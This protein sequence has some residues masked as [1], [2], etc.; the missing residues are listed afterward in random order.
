MN[1]QC[2]RRISVITPSY[3]QGQFLAE[4]IESVIGQEGDF[5]LDYIVV[6]G[7][8]T[9][10]SVEIIKHYENL[11]QNQ[12]WKVKCR[13]IRYRWISEKDQGQTDAIMKGFN[14]AEGEIL[15]W[16]NS[17]DLY[18]PGALSKV[19]GHFSANPDFSVVYGKT[20]FTDEAG[21]II[22]KYPTMSFDENLLPSFNFICQ[23]SVFFTK[24]AM[25][26]VGG[27]DLT[28]H[29][30]MDYDFWIRLSKKFRF[31]Y[32]DDFF[33]TYRLHQNSKT[34]SSQEAAANHA[35]SLQMILN[36][37]GFAPLNRVYA[38]CFQKLKY[39]NPNLNR[40]LLIFVALLL[41]TYNYF[42][43]NKYIRLSD[44][45]MINRKNMRN[46]SMDLMNMYKEY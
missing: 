9:D 30:V 40:H 10:S 21:Q 32:V 17:D 6:D 36:H 3:N 11:L 31:S 1:H 4:T 35:E 29:Y 44:L 46:L 18:L 26:A 16:L 24:A 20:Y 27:L 33:S 45:R 15:A 37:Y 8:S 14:L 5:A 42:K 7:G 12:A 25:E 23:P 28:L 38:S 2:P 13:A 43:I 19:L 39:R 22:G 34:I 41:T